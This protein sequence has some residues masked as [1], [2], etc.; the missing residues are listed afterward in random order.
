ME[1]DYNCSIH[2]EDGNPDCPECCMNLKRLAED[3]NAI[4]ITDEETKE[5]MGLD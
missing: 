4:I 5:R 2:G 3:N 1:P